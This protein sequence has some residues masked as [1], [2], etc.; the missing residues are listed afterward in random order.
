[1]RSFAL[2]KGMLSSRNL[3]AGTNEESGENNT[4]GSQSSCCIS[5]VARSQIGTEKTPHSKGPGAPLNVS[6]RKRRA[7]SSSGN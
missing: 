1:M 2:T 6:L 7:K 5:S 4:S 3:T